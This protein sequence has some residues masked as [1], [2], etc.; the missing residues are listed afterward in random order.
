METPLRELTDET[1][2][3][4]AR[5]DRC[6]RMDRGGADRT[7]VVV[8][9]RMSGLPTNEGPP[10]DSPQVALHDDGESAGGTGEW[11]SLGSLMSALLD[12]TEV[13]KPPRPRC[14]IVWL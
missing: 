9:V 1:A 8:D 4:D 5:H 7:G 11:Q 3:R 13:R 10:A 2:S 14:R 12:G 6:L